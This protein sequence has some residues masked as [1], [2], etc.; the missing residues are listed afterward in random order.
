MAQVQLL[1]SDNPEDG[2][3]LECECRTSDPED[4]NSM[5][6]IVGLYLADNWLGLVQ[7]ARMTHAQAI[8]REG[9]SLMKEEE[10]RALPAL[11]DEAG[12]PLY[13]DPSKL[14]KLQ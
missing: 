6:N 14:D 13:S 10:L 7:A 12:R 3:R 9:K 1:I 2:G 4:K 5:A 8:V 11:Q